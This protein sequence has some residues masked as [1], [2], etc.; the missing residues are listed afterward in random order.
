MDGWTSLIPN[1]ETTQPVQKI[2]YTIVQELQNH[3]KTSTY[4][5]QPQQMCS[6][7][8]AFDLLFKRLLL[9]LCSACGHVILS[10]KINQETA[11]RQNPLYFPHNKTPIYSFSCFP[12]VTQNI[13]KHLQ[14]NSTWLRP[15][16]TD[17]LGV[18]V[19][20]QKRVEG[21]ART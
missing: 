9:K 19:A 5:K 21:P 3:S 20:F 1:W 8:R 10:D 4:N 6:T 7:F 18:F 11:E 17:P 13:F 12:H 2:N 14:Q 15:L 16:R